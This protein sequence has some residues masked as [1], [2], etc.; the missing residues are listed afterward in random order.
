M[1]MGAQGICFAIAINTA[2]WTA[3]RLIRDGRITR[4]LIGVAGQSVPIHRRLVRF[5]KLGAERGVLATAIEANSPANRAGLRQNDIIVAFAGHH[6]S[7]V[8][9]LHRLLTAEVAGVASSLVVIRGTE[10]VELTITPE[11]VE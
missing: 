1:I 5:Y 3:G 2:I 7:G 9:D 8:D 10:L 11:R 6:V 4:S